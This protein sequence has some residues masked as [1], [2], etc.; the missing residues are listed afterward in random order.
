MT[1]RA[2]CHMPTV[3]C[4]GFHSVIAVEFDVLDAVSV[5]AKTQ[6][7]PFW[8]FVTVQPASG[9]PFAAGINTFLDRGQ[10]HAVVRV[11]G[12]GEIDIHAPA[13]DD[14]IV[15]AGGNEKSR[16]AFGRSVRDTAERTG[17]KSRLKVVV[18]QPDGL[19]R[20]AVVQQH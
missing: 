14:I 2:A 9:N 4:G 10:A 6:R 1:G 19:R 5:A 7:F 16:D 17:R 3:T 11:R 8:S 15:R 12:G 13:D 20:A 18:S